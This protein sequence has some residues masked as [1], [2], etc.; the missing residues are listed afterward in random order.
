MVLDQDADEALHR[1]ENRPM[2]HDWLYGVLL[3]SADVF[4]AQPLPACEK[5]SCRVPHCHDAVQSQ[6]F[7]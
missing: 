5:S 4:S 6:S 2:Q 1:S 3:S 7:I